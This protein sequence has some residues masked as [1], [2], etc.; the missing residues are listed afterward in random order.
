[1]Y[2]IICG[3]H[4]ILRAITMH[5]RRFWEPRALFIRTR[6]STS[7]YRPRYG[8][9]YTP[10]CAV[11]TEPLPLQNRRLNFLNRPLR[12]TRIPHRENP[13]SYF[14]EKLAGRVAKVLIKVMQAEETPRNLEEKAAA[15]LS[16][17]SFKHQAAKI[18]VHVMNTASDEYAAALVAKL[19]AVKR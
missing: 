14:E 19:K 13:R 8:R 3:I 18:N 17:K 4:N 1:M 2:G 9:P 11:L 7:D 5:I 10:W 6:Q 15:V 16:S 12:N